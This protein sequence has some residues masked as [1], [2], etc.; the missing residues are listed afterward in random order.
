MLPVVVP[1]GLEIAQDL[2]PLVEP[3]A[4]G[5]SR[6]LDELVPQVRDALQR[7][8]GFA[9]PSI[10]IR[11]NTSDMPD[12]TA[13]VLIDEVPESMFRIDSQ[14]VVVNATPERLAALGVAAQEFFDTAC[15][16]IAFVPAADRVAVQGLGLHT[17][18]AT[19]YL[20]H[21]LFEVVRG[22][23]QE[24]LGLDEVHRRVSALPPDL[25][26][27]TVPAVL[28]W[29]GLTHVLQALLQEDIGIGNLQAIVEALSRRD[30]QHDGIDECVEIARC[31]LSAQ[32]GDRFLAGESALRVLVAAAQAEAL[33]HGGLQ[34]AP[35][36]N[37][38]T[39]DPES[40]QHLLA[41]VR[42]QM[43]A[44][45]DTAAGVVL[46][47]ADSRVR[48]YLRRLVMLEFPKLHVLSRQELPTGMPIE[49]VGEFGV[50]AQAP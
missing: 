38:L 45:G 30:L 43:H 23:P 5:A 6:A 37:L 14:Q 8:Y 17:M 9:F 24:F 4:Q 13:R 1:I 33:L 11:G 10:R 29:I 19:E 21:A 47:V 39:L 48:P 20:F 40:V 50:D 15:G 25:V 49:I 44:L 12:G 16:R 34:R 32:I 18:D 2:I 42:Q 36:G 26:Q 46:L 41:A 35:S 27:R 28:S 7:Q 22:M 3:D 31:S